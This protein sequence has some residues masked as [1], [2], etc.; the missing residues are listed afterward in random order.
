MRL[1]AAAV[2]VDMT[3][4]LCVLQGDDPIAAEALRCDAHQ[5]PAAM[6]IS[7]RQNGRAER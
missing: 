6:T 7:R 5:P 4:G 1:Y 2:V 3:A